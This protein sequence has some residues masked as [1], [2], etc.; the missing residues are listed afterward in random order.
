MEPTY[1]HPY[2][3]KNMGYDT[4]TKTKLGNRG[5]SRI[6]SRLRSRSSLFKS[7]TII[8]HLITHHLLQILLFHVL[9]MLF[10]VK[11]NLYLHP[12]KMILKI[13]IFLLI[14]SNIV[15]SN[16]IICNL[17]EPD[18]DKTKLIKLKKK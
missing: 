8:L 15:S 18:S 1:D 7:Y 4:S 10:S 11:I 9:L 16:A 13:R 3:T 14:C 6:K 12:F 2:S 17:G 5:G